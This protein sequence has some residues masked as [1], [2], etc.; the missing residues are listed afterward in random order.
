M[1]QYLY[2]IKNKDQLN[3]I[4][5]K[6]KAE[7][8]N[9]NKEQVLIQLNTTVLDEEKIQN[10]IDFIYNRIP[11]SQII[12][13]SSAGNIYKNKYNSGINL[14]FNILEKKDSKIDIEMYDMRKS[15]VEN[16]IYKIKEK[17]KSIPDIK[18]IEIYHTLYGGDTAVLCDLLSSLPTNIQIFGGLVCNENILDGNSFVATHKDKIN[19]TG[20]S[21]IFYSGSELNFYIQKISGWKPISKEFTITKAD[22]NIIYEF[23]G[24]SAF[25]IYKKYLNIE[26]DSH[27][28]QNALEFPLFCE[29]NG[30]TIIRD[31]MMCDSY[32]AIKMSNYIHEGTTVRF[33]YGEPSLIMQTIND[34]CKELQNFTPDILH[35]I[36][37]AARAIFWATKESN[38]ELEPFK[39][40]AP[41]T[42]YLSHGEII[43]EKNLVNQ[44]NTVLVVAAIREGKVKERKNPA[45]INEN[46][47]KET[48]TVPLVTRMAS[49]I[50]QVASELETANNKLK[51]NN[52]QLS[53]IALYDKLTGLNNRYAFEKELKNIEENNNITPVLVIFD[54]NGLKFIND[55]FGHNEGDAL[56]KAASD[57]IKASFELYGTCYRIGG[58]EFAAIINIPENLKFENIYK[59][60]MSYIDKYNKTAVYTLSIATGKSDILNGKGKRKTISDWKMDADIDMYRDKARFHSV[61]MLDKNKTID[62]LISC[63]VGMIDA[64]DQYTAY[65]S[66]RVYKM[67]V[68]IAELLALSENSIKEIATAAYL[69][70][71][72]KVGISD[73]IITKT[74]ALTDEEYNKIKEHPNIG[75]KILIESEYSSSIVNMVLHHHEK[76]DGTGYPSRLKGDEI[77]IGSRI[78]TIADSIDAMISKRYYREAFTL[79]QCYKEIEKNIGT[80]YDPSITRIVLTHFREIVEAIHQ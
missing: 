8:K 39:A 14:S 50:S 52:K 41:C 32:G 28:F 34:T 61:N 13:Y 55:T 6:Q 15:S 46:I 21:V 58:D 42:G 79:E 47:T 59:A 3:D 17:A 57:A 11:N 19:H 74:A 69:H 75:A 27:F 73:E 29:Y 53:E 54:V 33:S 25:D 49:F 7:L 10:Y 16:I 22:R 9:K 62:K 30:I 26:N 76:Y 23:D 51:N 31:P 2:Q 64:K 80:M 20:I 78:I 4:L 66:K 37:C 60:F 5:T 45:V 65:H 40:V 68:A 48:S 56:I 12:C 18:A 43:R 67:S 71:I 35:I 44:H 70:D 24:Y 38:I 1:R 72:G 36:S 63:I 77:P